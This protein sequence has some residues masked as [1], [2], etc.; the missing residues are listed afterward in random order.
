MVFLKRTFLG[1]KCRC[2]YHHCIPHA[3]L[4]KW[5][6][7]SCALQ[8][9]FFLPNSPHRASHNPQESAN[10]VQYEGW[11]FLHKSKLDWN[12]YLQLSFSQ[13]LIEVLPGKCGLSRAVC[14]PP[15]DLMLDWME[16]RCSF[17]SGKFGLKS[18]NTKCWNVWVK[19]TLKS[20]WVENNK[21]WT[22]QSSKLTSH[23]TK[24]FAAT[25]FHCNP[26]CDALATRC[27]FKQH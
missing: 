9:L 18:A 8:L 27:L 1:H 11:I 12:Q 2:M 16:R 15:L 20:G 7:M 26:Y 21:S 13:R 14:P 22:A 6:G 4:H 5:A 10:W 23:A 25:T 19:M 3:E 24:Y 17:K